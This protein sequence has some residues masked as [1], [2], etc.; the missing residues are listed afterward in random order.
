MFTYIIIMILIVLIGLFLLLNNKLSINKKIKTYLFLCFIILGGI[1]SLRG[2]GVGNDTYGYYL[3]FNK[4]NNISWEVIYNSF[5]IYIVEGIGKDV[6]YNILVKTFQ[7]FSS[8]FQFFLLFVSVF[9]YYC[10][11]KFIINN[12]IGSITGTILSLIVF[13]VLFYFVFS[14]TALRQSIT[15]A[16]TFIAYDFIKKNKLIPFLLIILIASF[17]HKS[18]LIYIPFYFLC[19]IKKTRVFLILCLLLFPIL[20]IF[21]NSF[22]SFI[23]L[24]AGEN[25]YEENDGAG[26]F[27]FATIIITLTLAVIIQYK[28]LI[29]NDIYINHYI[30]AL[31][32]TLILLPLAW[33]HSALLRIS[34]YFSIFLIFI[35]PRLLFTIPKLSFKIK[36]NLTIC[37]ICTLLFL[38]IK[39]NSSKDNKEYRFFWEPIKLGKNYE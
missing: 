14:M 30:I 12:N 11:Y 3:D 37:I 26:V 4:T 38:F 28:S 2:L 24:F 5:K 19:K 29:K 16:C 22:L 6:G 39:S 13:Y 1:S 15:M 17:I 33:V 20:L 8:E 7:I 25:V 18:I 21:K 35:I 31:G 32:V 10:F 36:F 9:F 34:M 23:N 27:F